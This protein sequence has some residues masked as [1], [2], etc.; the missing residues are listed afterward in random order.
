MLVDSCK[1]VCDEVSDSVHL[2]SRSLEKATFSLYTETTAILHCEGGD[3]RW[4]TFP[5]TPAIK[6]RI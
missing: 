4:S 6:L 1:L 3:R 5:K 2:D